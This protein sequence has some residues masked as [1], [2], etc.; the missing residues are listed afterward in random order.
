MVHACVESFSNFNACSL[1]MFV[2]GINVYMPVLT[3]T[4]G[5]LGGINVYMPVLTVTRGGLGGINVSAMP[6]LTVTRGGPSVLLSP[7]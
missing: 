5:G 1:G 7:K 4:R 2:G 6:V 3:V